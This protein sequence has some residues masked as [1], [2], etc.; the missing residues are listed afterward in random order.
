MGHRRMLTTKITDDDRFITLPSSAQALYLHLSMSADDDGF[1]NEVATSMF[2]SHATTAD[3]EMLLERKYLYQFDDGVIVIKH[4]RMANALRRDRYTPTAFQE[5]LAKLKLDENGAYTMVRESPDELGCRLVA[6]RLPQDK[7][8]KDNLTKNNIDICQQVVDVYHEECPSLP[9]VRNL[10]D[11]RKKHILA[12]LK[13]HT[14]DELRLAFQKAEAS[15]WC[16]GRSGDWKCNLE[17]MMKSENNLLK[18]LEGNYDNHDSKIDKTMD[19]I[20][21]LGMTQEEIDEQRRLFG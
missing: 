5:D 1:S 21:K 15:D 4:W 9:R 2:K 18:V 17:W 6:K 19:S 12:R 3:L 7:L 16:T 11:T 20:A 14:L 13:D 8:T 10:S